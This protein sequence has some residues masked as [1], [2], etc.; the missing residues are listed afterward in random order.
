MKSERVLSVFVAA[1]TVLVTL[2]LW[3]CSSTGG[4]GY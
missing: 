4:G 2:S 3:G 1:I